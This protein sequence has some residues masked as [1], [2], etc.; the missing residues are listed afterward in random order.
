MRRLAITELTILLILALTLT[1]CVKNPGIVPGEQQG[2]T[3]SPSQATNPIGTS[4]PKSDP[5]ETEATEVQ[6]T[7]SLPVETET[8]E[9]ETDVPNATEKETQPE[10]STE[11][12]T[13]EPTEENVTQTEPAKT[14]EELAQAYEEYMNLSAT[15]QWNFILTF[16]C[17]DDFYSW[18]TAA[19]AAYQQIHPDIIIDSNDN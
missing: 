19:K 16:A 8:T 2:G 5:I 1:A 14:T 6:T 7:E 15:E 4:T 17:T 12:P 11:E 3:A 9:P 13:E 10:D 18:R